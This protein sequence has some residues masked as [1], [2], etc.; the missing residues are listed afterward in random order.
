MTHSTRIDFIYL[1]E[2]DMVKA[3]VTDMPACVAAMDETFAL[4]HKGDFRMA[5]PNNNSHGAM[6]MFPEQ[7][8]H[9]N[10]PASGPDRRL[11]AMP[12]YLGGSFGACGVKW[13][14]SNIENRD[15]GLP[16]SILMFILTDV[17]TSAPLALMSANLLSA[18]RTG[19][20]CGV[21]AKYL[22]RKDSKAVGILG[23]GVMGRT[24]L[25]AFV[26]ACPDLDTLRL[27]SRGAANRD[28]FVAWVKETY[29]QI[30]TIDHVDSIEE[31]L[32]DSDV[33]AYCNSGKTGDPDTYPRIKK[34]WVKPGTFITTISLVTLADDAMGPEVRK[35]CDAISIYEAWAEEMPKPC[36]ETVPLLGVQFMDL[37]DKGR[38]TSDD[39]EDL[40]AIAAGDSPGRQN[41]EEVVVMSV[42]GM[43]IEDVAWATIVYRNA[44]KQGIGV[45]L[46]LWDKPMLS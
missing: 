46:N 22:A 10:M 33:V 14:G 7:P 37:I 34:E 21:G 3:G 27:K 12:A 45:K 40:G 25:A 23:P 6:L 20:I 26:A 32:R 13:Y 41:D 43:P 31:L 1:S 29:P 5:G 24:S 39:L 2:A 17:V 11:M 36:H 4:M 15:L 8:E 44:I 18:Y 28:A 42:G 38:L 35:V 9:E 16:R 19:A 30:T